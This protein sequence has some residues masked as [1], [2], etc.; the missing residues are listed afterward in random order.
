MSTDLSQIDFSRIK[1]VSYDLGY[2]ILGINAQA[3]VRLIK[4]H[5]GW[6]FSPAQILKADRELRQNYL[7][8]AALNDAVQ[9]SDFS[10]VLCEMLPYLSEDLLSIAHP[11]EISAFKQ[12]CRDYHH[13]L[14]FFD[15]IYHDALA[16]LELLFTAG[17]PMIVISNAHGTLHRDLEHFGLLKYFQLVI[18]SGAEGVSKPDAEIFIRAIDRLGFKAENFLHVGDNYTADVEGARAVGMQAALY[19]PNN[20]YNELDGHKVRFRNHVDLAQCIIQGGSIPR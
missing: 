10:D 16:A 20:M 17:I 14:N 5:F 18:D 9:H 4:Q 2:T 12:G 11:H 13:N 8:V 19:D 6:T 1:V 7:H 3:I 15:Q